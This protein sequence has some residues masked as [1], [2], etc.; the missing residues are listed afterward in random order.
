MQMS[1]CAVRWRRVLV[2][3]MAILKATHAGI[4]LP[5]TF[6]FLSKFDIFTARFV[7]HFLR[8]LSD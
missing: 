1:V 6:F 8:D 7:L 2:F 3:L 5:K 4:T